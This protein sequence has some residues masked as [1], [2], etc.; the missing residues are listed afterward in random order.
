MPQETKLPEEAKLL[1]DTQ[2][3]NTVVVQIFGWASLR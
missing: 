3:L 1:I 2:M